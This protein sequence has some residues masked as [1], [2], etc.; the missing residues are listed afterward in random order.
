M[1]VCQQWTFNDSPWL[2]SRWFQTVYNCSFWQTY[3]GQP[4]LFEYGTGCQWHP[5]NQPL[6]R[7]VVRIRCYPWS[8]ESWQ[9]FHIVGLCACFL[10]SRL[11]T[12]ALKDIPVVCM[13]I[14]CHLCASDIRLRTM[15][16][17]NEY[18]FLKHRKREHTEFWVMRERHG[19]CAWLVDI[20]HNGHTC[21]STSY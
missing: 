18:F 3:N 15:L 10:T 8:A 7:P 2:K 13:Q 19:S 20:R 4:V 5:S 12:V 16:T 1:S 17:K 14:I 21:V 6:Q 11:T 9:V